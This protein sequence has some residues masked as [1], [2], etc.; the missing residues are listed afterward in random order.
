[1]YAEFISPLNTFECDSYYITL[2]A[3]FYHL[4]DER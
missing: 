3:L 2:I 1:M 4:L